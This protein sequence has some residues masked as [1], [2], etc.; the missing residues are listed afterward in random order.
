MERLA[1]A[2]ERACDAIVTFNGAALAADVVTCELQVDETPRQI[3]AELQLLRK[4][5]AEQRERAGAGVEL[6][7]S[8]S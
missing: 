2:A 3:L 6:V 1:A 8:K 5:F 7:F 4:D